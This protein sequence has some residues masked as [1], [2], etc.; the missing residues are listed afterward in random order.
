MTDR[1]RS[2][3]TEEDEDRIRRVVENLALDEAQAATPQRA[4]RARALRLR[5]EALLQSHRRN[6]DREGLLPCPECS[7]WSDLFDPPSGILRCRHCG[8]QIHPCALYAHAGIWRFHV[9]CLVLF[10]GL[11]AL[12]AWAAVSSVSVPVRIL[13]SL[14]ACVL[15]LL[16][17]PYWLYAARQLAWWLRTRR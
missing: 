9:V 15:A 2:R 11:A 12:G 3:Y 4:T 16:S 8:S 7:E 1:S 5:G 13:A 17:L 6:R 10:S 14:G